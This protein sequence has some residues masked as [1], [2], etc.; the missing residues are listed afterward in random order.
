MLAKIRLKT[1]TVA[2]IFSFIGLAAPVYAENPDHVAKLKNTKQ[3]PGCDL[4]G[5]DL[6]KLNLKNANLKGANLRSAN[7]SES[8]LLQADW[9]GQF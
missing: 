2:I 3:C 4:S 5:A 8:N 7:L 9:K 1:L 6:S